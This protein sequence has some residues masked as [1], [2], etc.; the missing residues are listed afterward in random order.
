VGK[1]E[2]G[3]PE[4]HSYKERKSKLEKGKW[5]QIVTGEA[6]L[7]SRNKAWPAERNWKLK[8]GKWE[9]LASVFAGS[10]R[11]SLFY[12]PFSNFNFPKTC[13]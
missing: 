13:R 1:A 4:R 9:L 5:K 10:G 6:K 2:R 3:P 8:K 11:T 12:F 7:A